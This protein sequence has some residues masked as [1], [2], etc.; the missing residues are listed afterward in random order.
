DDQEREVRL[1]ALDSLIN[2][3]VEAALTQALEKPHADVRVRAAKALA[4]HGNKAAAAT[5]LQ[6]ATAPEPQERERVADWLSLTEIALEGRAALAPGSAV[7]SHR[8]PR[9]KGPP[10]SIRKG[11]AKALVWL[12]PAGSPEALRQALQHSDP[13][14]KYRA[15]F[16]LA[17]QGDPAGASLVFSQ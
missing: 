8:I 1:L 5:L 15:A 2:N 11:V 13:Q 14:V 12:S 17:I 4:R 16:G 3:D 6:L 7:A 10:A 9:L